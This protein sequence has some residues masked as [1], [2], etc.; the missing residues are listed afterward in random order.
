MKRVTVAIIGLGS[1]GKD[2]YAKCQYILKD[3]MQIVAIADI[4]PQKVEDVSTKYNIPKQMCFESGEKLLEQD[5]LADAVFICT[6]DKQHYE[7]AIAALKKGYHILLEK[8]ISPNLQE[9]KQICELANK[10]NLKVVVCHV[11][12]YTAFYQKIKQIID[13]GK[14][15]DIVSIQAIE[16][17]CYWH[18]AHSFVRG[19]WRNSELSSPMILQKSCH[20][21]D[22]LLWLANKKCKNVSSFGDLKLFK[23]EN[24]PKG[25]A[26]RCID[27]KVKSSC[28]FDAEKIYLTNE[29]TGILNGNTDWP[30]NILALNP[31][32]QSIKEAIKASPYGRCVYHCDNNVVDHQIV[33]LELEANTT[34]SF[35]MC[36]FTSKGYRNLKVMGTLGDIEANTYDNIIDIGVFGKEHEIIDVH[37]LTTD[38]SGHGGGDNRLVKDFIDMVR[39]NSSKTLALTS[40]EQSVE[41]HYVALA[42]EQSRLSHGKVISLDEFIK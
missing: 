31:T 17:V 3:E 9:C 18:Q 4:I 34:I 14:I 1:R 27:C 38:F 11:L 35:T 40:I 16:N 10:L 7:H 5:K 37:T 2:T 39:D 32:E 12:R 24:A 8:P 25:S 33:N 21:M 19:N 42:A 20:D 6:Q 23:K 22:I 26:L 29:S 15:G 36:A 13:S 30:C 28:P 41:S